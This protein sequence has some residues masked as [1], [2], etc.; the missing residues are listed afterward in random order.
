MR[1]E[2]ASEA[3][4]VNQDDGGEDDKV[5]NKQSTLKPKWSFCKTK[6]KQKSSS[7]KKVNLPDDNLDEYFILSQ[8]KNSQET[9]DVTPT[10]LPKKS[11]ETESKD[12]PTSSS[13]GD[14]HKSP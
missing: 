4:K 13:H 1:E 8:D 5:A 2:A 6:G 3:A 11:Q 10:E 7:S 14:V 12:D 9:T